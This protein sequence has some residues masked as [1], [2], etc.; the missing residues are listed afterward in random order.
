MERRFELLPEAVQVHLENGDDPDD[1]GPVL[2]EA[3]QL[4][5]DRHVQALLVISG[6][7]DPAT[8]ESVSSA[9]EQI[10]ASGAAPGRIA[11]VAYTL[12]QYA[13]YHFAERYASRFGI[14]AKVMVSTRDARA[15]LGLREEARARA[16]APASAGVPFRS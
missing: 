11:F 2:V 13:T 4:A 5:F 7:G 1:I 6:L 16:D 12:R 10:H 3:A 8:S 15:W 9:L 14:T